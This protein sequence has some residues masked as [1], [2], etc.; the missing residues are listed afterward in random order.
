MRRSVS[1]NWIIAILIL[2][3]IFSFYKTTLGIHSDE[4]HS[5]AVGDMIEEGNVFFKECWFYLQM[6]AVFTSPL[7]HIYKLLTGG[8]EGILLFFRIVSVLVQ[9]LICFFFYNTFSKNYNKSFVLCASLVLFVYIPDFQSFNYKQEFIWFSVLEIIYL[10]RY[11]LSKRKRNLILLGLTIAAN[12][13][14]YPTS[15]LQFILYIILL[16]F[17]ERE[18]K[19]NFK[20]ICKSLVCVIVP[21]VICACC[22]LGWILKDISVVEFWYY[23][24]NVFKDENLNASFITKLSHPIIKFLILGMIT[25]IP[26]LVAIRVKVVKNVISKYNIPVIT[27]L[28]LGAFSLQAYIERRCITWHCITYPYSLLVFLIPLL[29][30][31]K[32]NKKCHSILFFF[33]IPAIVS[34]LIL[35]LAS[36]QGNITSMYGMIMAA[37]GFILMLGEEG[38]DYFEECINERKCCC[39]GI[40]VMALA[41]YIFPVYEQESVM[42][43]NEM[44]RTIFT[45]RVEVKDGPAKGMRL[46]EYTYLRYTNL[47]TVVEQNVNDTDQLFIVDDHYNASFGYLASEGNYATFSPQGGW[48]VATS[49]RATQYFDE[50]PEKKP[51]VIV[52]NMDYANMT[53][54]EYVETTSVGIFLENNCYDIVDQYEEYIVLRELKRTEK[55]K[56]IF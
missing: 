49:N 19:K 53:Y 18:E 26:M 14:A 35:A 16:I 15:I 39:I 45:D 46:G 23:F 31:R 52:I 41:M 2:L 9:L 11:Y 10:Y 13:L 17:I 21:C 36:N 38:C 51:T 47:C 48:G 33:G 25:L 27:F 43:S 50:N 32:K 54:K 7:I 3:V 6:S 1:K 5:I 22:F 34:V 40:V 37:L 42:L 30:L 56:L 55:E 24:W 4:V 28:L 29:Y 44:Q 20:N 8:T 12:V